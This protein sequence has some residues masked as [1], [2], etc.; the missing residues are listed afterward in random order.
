VAV[1]NQRAPD[2]FCLMGPTASG[3]TNLAVELVKLHPFE[4]INVDS[5]QIYRGM[6]IGTGKP[7]QATLKIAPHRLL[8]IRDPAEF[9]SAADFQVDATREIFTIIKSG[10]V[11]LLVGGTMLY[12]R[13]LRDGLA[14]LPKANKKVRE[15]IEI[16]AK[17]HGWDRVHNQL[18]LVDPEAAARIHPKDPQRL[19]RA[20]EVFLVSGK[21]LTDFFTEEAEKRSYGQKKQSF[22][23]HF[24]GIQ[25]PDR[26]V[27]HDSISKRL[28]QML[29]DGFVAEVEELYKRGDLSDSLPS[30]KSVGYRQIWQFLSGELAYR[31]MVDKSKVATRQLAKRQYTW[32]RN[33]P[34]L[35]TLTDDGLQSRDKVLNYCKSISI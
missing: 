16:M 29:A 12:F 33:W 18:A 24:F 9:Y 32:L 4:I 25:P 21:R 19:Q 35:N 11:P 20:L 13:V 15:D 22:N 23:F 26:A 1:K 3:K 14:D 28:N 17:N 7:C 30:I 6:D 27:L 31:E 8:D 34:S 2:V 10:K 5:A